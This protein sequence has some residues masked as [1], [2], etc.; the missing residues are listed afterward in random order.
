MAIARLAKMFQN[1]YSQKKKKKKVDVGLRK[2]KG[3]VREWGRCWRKGV[4]P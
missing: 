1:H 2:L 4:S 3:R